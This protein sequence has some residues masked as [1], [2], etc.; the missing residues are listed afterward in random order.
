ML[1]HS[2]RAKY[3]FT[4]NVNY[5]HRKIVNINLTGRNRYA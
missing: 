2:E 4:G 3:F 1:E 5:I